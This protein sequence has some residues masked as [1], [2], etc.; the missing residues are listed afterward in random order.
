LTPDIEFDL[1]RQLDNGFR[2]MAVLEQRV[3]DGLGA[4][5]EQ[6]AIEA[7]LLLRDLVAASVL[8]DEDDGRCRAARGRFDELHV[9]YPSGG[10]SRTRG[11]A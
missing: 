11:A 4:V 1:T 2:V 7:V 9:R 8:A 10:E 6:A 5:D 3:F